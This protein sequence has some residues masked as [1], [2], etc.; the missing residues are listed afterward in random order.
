M[1]STLSRGREKECASEG[2]AHWGKGLLAQM[3]LCS[4]SLSHVKITFSQSEEINEGSG[5]GYRGDNSNG[6]KVQ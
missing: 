6:E 3:G 4:L 1:Q 5:R 2:L